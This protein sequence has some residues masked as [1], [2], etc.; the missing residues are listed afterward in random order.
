MAFWILRTTEIST[1]SIDES[2][3]VA[4]DDPFC[5]Q[6]TLAVAALVEER[7]S[8]AAA[9]VLADLAVKHRLQPGEISARRFKKRR[10][11]SKPC[12]SHVALIRNRL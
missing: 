9:S 5:Q 3:D 10:R 7:G 8:G 6:P 4:D 11:S 1:V 12:P 2:G